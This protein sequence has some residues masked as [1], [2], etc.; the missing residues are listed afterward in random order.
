MVHGYKTCDGLI[1]NKYIIFKN[2]NGEPVLVDKNAQYFVLRVDKDPHAQRALHSYAIS[3]AKDN[4][5]LSQ[6][7]LKWILSLPNISV[8][9]AQ[10]G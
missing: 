9:D 7:I 4:E 8:N 1:P 10:K 5:K 3:V 6:D 2:K